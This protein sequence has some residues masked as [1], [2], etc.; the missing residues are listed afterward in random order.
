MG[1]SRE[2]RAWRG[3][4][5]VDGTARPVAQ[6]VERIWLS[7]PDQSGTEAALL[8]QAVASNWIAPAGPFIDAFEHAI[9]CATGIPHVAALTSGT[10]ALT[11]A[12]RLLDVGPGDAV[13][14]STLT[15]KATIAP[16]ALMGARPV[17]LDVDPGTWTLDPGLL[18]EALAAAARRNALPKVVVPV[19]LYGHPADLATIGAVCARWGV[20]VVSDSAEGL[21]ATMHGRHAG[22]G[23]LMTVY[24]FNGNKIVTCGGGG[25]LA[26][27]NAGLVARARKLATQAREPAPHYEHNELGYNF[28]LSNL[29]A[30]AGVA[31][32]SDLARRV[33]RRRSI[34]D[35][36]RAVV[37]TLPG[38]G[39]MPEAPW[40]RSSRW[41]S[42][43]VGPD[44]FQPEALRCAMDAA[45]IE[46]RPLWKPMHMQ[47]VFRDAE[48]IGGAV[49]EGLFAHGLCL[50]SGGGMSHADQDRVID[51]LRR[52]LSSH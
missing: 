9:A 14:T 29:L 31:Q 18:E 20:P 13:W 41:L 38:F 25:A 4:F 47:P 36:Y 1:G 16:A 39:M 19:D 48:R 30:A 8:A 37:A 33:A 17:F 49:A 7:P 24:S 11:L 46:A 51:V 26:S 21:G 32:M 35:A 27:A 34:F 28:R 3:E 42:V 23:A 45:G 5:Q 2:V 6:P 22:A 12:Y 44:H 50:P 10:G 43:L 15:F 40:A 52:M